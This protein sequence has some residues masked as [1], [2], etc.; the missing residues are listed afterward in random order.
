M[1]KLLLGV[2]LALVLAELCLSALELWAPQLYSEADPPA[3]VY[4]ETVETAG[5]PVM[6]VSVVELSRPNRRGK[7]ASG[8]LYRTNSLGVRGPEYGPVPDVFRIVITGDSFTMGAGVSEEDAYPGRLQDLLNRGATERRYEVV[9]LGIVGLNAKIVAR[10][11]RRLLPRLNPQLLV[12]G[13]TVNDINGP[14]YMQVDPA[15]AVSWREYSAGFTRLP[16][17]VLRLAGSGLL[18]IRQAISPHRGSYAFAIQRNYFDNPRA[19]GALVQ[20]IDRMKALADERDI[21]MVLFIHTNLEQLKVLHPYRAIYRKVAHA[22]TQR[23]IFVASSFEQLSGLRAHSLWVGPHNSHP[24]PAAHALFAEALAR[25]TRALPP[26][27]LG[28]EMP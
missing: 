23:G 15:D 10:R 11:T 25:G 20:A 28:E 6:D 3:T 13:F 5:L 17:R 22:A 9:N 12:Y 19:W 21:C 16:T 18:A 24:S 2:C 27:C 14:A 4:P 1:K 26:R 7:L 8:A